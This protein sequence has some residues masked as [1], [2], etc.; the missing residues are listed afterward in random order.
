LDG[1]THSVAVV[2]TLLFSP[3]TRGKQFVLQITPMEQHA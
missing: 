2:V 1:V 3:E